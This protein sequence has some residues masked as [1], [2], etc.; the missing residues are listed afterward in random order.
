MRNF[1][2]QTFVGL[3]VVIAGCHV[4]AAGLAGAGLVDAGDEAATIPPNP[5]PEAGADAGA[6]P[7]VATTPDALEAPVDGAS[8]VDARE[9]PDLPGT[10]PPKSLRDCARD[11][12]LAACGPCQD[13]GGA[14]LSAMCRA[15]LACLDTDPPY[16]FIPVVGGEPDPL[17]YCA[18]SV[19]VRGCL[20]RIL[21][22]CLHPPPPG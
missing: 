7:E 14:N 19:V 21:D 4:D 10:V 6:A 22:P 18:P 16:T 3:V 17:G 12:D 8:A 11:A 5:H 13:I 15:D 1:G 9:S 20:T 2:W